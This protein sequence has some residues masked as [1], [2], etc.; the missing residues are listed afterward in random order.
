MLTGTCT[1]DASQSHFRRFYWL[2]STARGEDSVEAEL[3]PLADRV[4]ESPTL[5]T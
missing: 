4:S 3:L 2:A 5:P 1:R